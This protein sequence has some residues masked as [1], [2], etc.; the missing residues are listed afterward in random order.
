MLLGLV[1]SISFVS[2]T[3]FAK[4]TAKIDAYVSYNIWDITFSGKGLVI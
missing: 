2:E 1:F 4:Y 3:V